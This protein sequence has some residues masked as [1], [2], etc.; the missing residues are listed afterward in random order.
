VSGRGIYVAALM[1]GLIALFVFIPGCGRLA[2][3]NNSAQPN[4]ITGSLEYGGA[5]RTYLLH[6]PASYDGEKAVPLVFAFHGGGGD[7]QGMQSLTHLNRIADEQGFLVVYPDGLDKQW[8]DGRPEINPGVDDV[9][10]IS[11]LIDKLE[12]DYDIDTGMIYSTGISNGGFF[13]Q[14]LAFE[15]SDKIAAVAP[16][17]ALLGENLSRTTSPSGPIPIM[18]I[19]GTDDPLVPWNGGEINAGLADR[20]RVLSEPATISFWVKTNGC[21]QTPTVDYYP[22]RDASDGTRIRREVY[23]GGLDS[24]EV[25]L[26]AVEGGGHTWPG[27]TQYASERLIGKTS[28]DID[29]GE[30]IWEFFQEHK[31]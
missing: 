6:L 20:G 3:R 11:T 19:M 28:K 8:N 14:R 15:L 22:D 13:S 29:A 5:H 17:A 4:D 30:V 24:S 1:V 23:S 27:G 25:V 12:E 7:G 2:R 9:G 10:F 18:I 31:K 16:V 21:S 26:L